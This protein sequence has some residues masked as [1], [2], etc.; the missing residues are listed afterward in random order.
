MEYQYTHLQGIGRHEAIPAK[1]LKPG[2]TLVWNFGYTSSLKAVKPSKTGKTVTLTT[3]SSNGEQYER[4]F[5]V[6]TLIAIQ[7][8]E[9]PDGRVIKMEPGYSACEYD[10][11]QKKYIEEAGGRID[12]KTGM[13]YISRKRFNSLKYAGRSI[14]NHD[15]RTWM[16]PGSCL[17][18]E[19]QHFTITD[20]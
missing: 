5:G 16:L 10:E 1:E 9:T 7:T 15:I 8:D 17:I 11:Y 19:K 14:H 18:F 6:N 20:N 4:K 12:E 13:I 3:E 2:M